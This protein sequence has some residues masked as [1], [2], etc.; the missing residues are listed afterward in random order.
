M[1][2]LRIA[3][4]PHRPNGKGLPDAAHRQQGLSS[5]LKPK[6]IFFLYLFLTTYDWS[7]LSPFHR[8]NPFLVWCELERDSRSFRKIGHIKRAINRPTGLC[9]SR[10]LV[11]QLMCT[12]DYQLLPR[13]TPWRWGE[14]K[15]AAAATA[16]EG[17]LV[18]PTAPTSV[19]PKLKLQVHC[20]LPLLR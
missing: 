10:G 4:G 3:K 12:P 13:H 7:S 1:S 9:W 20:G 11:A 14:T 16:S 6:Y 8:F 19:P 18:A 5:N 15:L 2:L 17:G